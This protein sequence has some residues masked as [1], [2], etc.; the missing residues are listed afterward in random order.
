MNLNSCVNKRKQGRLNFLFYGV[1]TERNVHMIAHHVLLLDGL[2]VQLA[3][4]FNKFE[5]QRSWECRL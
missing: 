3:R 2:I 5:L 1:T 4:S